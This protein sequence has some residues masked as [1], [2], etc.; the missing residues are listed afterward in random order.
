MPGSLLCLWTRRKGWQR[1]ASG[2]HPER[3]LPGGRNAGHVAPSSA[4]SV[5]GRAQEGAAVALP[6]RGAWGMV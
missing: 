3:A 1:D 5:T 4:P 6:E 2:G